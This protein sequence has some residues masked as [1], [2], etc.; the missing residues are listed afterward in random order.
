MNAFATGSAGD[1]L[2]AVSDALLRRLSERELAGVLAHEVS[3]MANGDLAVMAFADLVSRL[4]SLLSLLGQVLLLLSVPAMLLGLAEPA[5]LAILVLLA[6]PTLSALM[7]LALSRNREHEA[8]R[9]AAELTGDPAG[10]A[11][12]L[13][14][15]ERWQGG[16]WEQ[17][18]MP[19]RRVPDPSLLRTHPDT[20]ER[21]ARLRE[22]MPHP[23][24]PLP[25]RPASTPYPLDALG[26]PRAPTMRRPRRYLLGLWY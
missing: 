19:G 15:L 4:C 17:V 21:I 18:I 2:I 16:F 23:T 7:Q 10:L 8:D 14:K 26:A 9:S 12:A 5:W 11:S 1:S 20:S 3:H 6:A 13:D 24:R 25:A 22:L